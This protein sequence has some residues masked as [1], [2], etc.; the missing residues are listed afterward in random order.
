MQPFEKKIAA[1]SAA[2]NLSAEGQAPSKSQVSAATAFLVSKPDKAAFVKKCAKSPLYARLVLSAA[3]P[4]DAFDT[5][6]FCALHKFLYEPKPKCGE[7]R[8]GDLMLTGGSCTDPKLLRGSLKN[9]LGKL[10]LLTGAPTVSK[11]DFAAALCCY[12]RELIILSPFAYGNAVVRRAFVRNFCHARGF[13]LNYAA[14]SKKELLAAEQTAFATDDPQPLFTLF[15][16]CLNYLQEEVPAQTRLSAKPSPRS[17][18]PLRPAPAP[19]P[20]R[21]ALTQQEKKELPRP[22]PAPAPASSGETLRELRELRRT[23]SDLSSRV[24]EIIQSIS[25]D[26]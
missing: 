24:D 21:S 1:L 13:S 5:D 23:L 12:V 26:E 8:T 11:A 19:A 4:Q 10:S 7:L 9:V 14:A 16:K 25:K 17:A 20:P 6:A 2:A 3:E 15:C 18:P 22:A